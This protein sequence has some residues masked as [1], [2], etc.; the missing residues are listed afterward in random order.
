MDVPQV[1]FKLLR[2]GAQVP[3]YAKP[4]DAGADLIFCPTDGQSVTLNRGETYILETGLAIQLPTGWEAQVRS[5]SGHATKGFFVVNSPGTVDTGYR[6][7]I[8]VIA[9]FA[10][11]TDIDDNFNTAAPRVFTV[12][13]GDR[14]AQLVFKPCFQAI[15]SQV[16]ELSDSSRGTAGFGST[17]K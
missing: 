16:E 14:I 9:H 6:G 1:K 8:K 15:F 5:R 10:R 11:G 3:V 2:P 7:E 17:G 13:P 12:N 4:G